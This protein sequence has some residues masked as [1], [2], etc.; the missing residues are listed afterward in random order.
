M[1]RPQ[2]FDGRARLEVAASPLLQ[3]SL[4]EALHPAHAQLVRSA[5]PSG[6]RRGDEQRL[7]RR[8]ATALAAMALSTPAGVIDLH[9]GVTPIS[10]TDEVA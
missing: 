9:G 10:W 4:V 7:A 3:G 6:F 1:G 5:V 8:P 2:S